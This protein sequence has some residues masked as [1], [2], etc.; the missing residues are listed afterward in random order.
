MDR[1]QEDIRRTVAAKCGISAGTPSSYGVVPGSVSRRLSN[2]SDIS[3]H[4]S[5]SG[6]SGSSSA[7]GSKT[8]VNGGGGN[9]SRLLGDFQ[10]KINNHQNN[11]SNTL[12]NGYHRHRQQHQQPV[13]GNPSSSATMGRTVNGN[14]VRVISKSSS[15]SS[16]A[17][18]GTAAT[19]TLE[20]RRR[21]SVSPH[22][23]LDRNAII[24]ASKHAAP[25]ILNAATG[26]GGSS[27]GSVGGSADRWV[28]AMAAPVM[29]TA[30]PAAAGD[31]MGQ[32]QPGTYPQL[33]RDSLT[34]NP[35]YENI[36]GFPAIPM[37][38]LH[39]QQAPPPPPPPYTGTN[40]QIVSNGTTARYNPRYF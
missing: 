32:F 10:Q 1:Y 18:G 24:A 21:S 14:N 27:K 16:L 38:G 36:E 33:K 39:L 34:S 20:N 37:R 12:N 2:G 4:G 31:V 26:S 15:A 30:E 13:I 7:A 23:A 3:S 35:I 8:M 25:K 17:R 5:S 9:V 28:A 40:H 22:T 29:I 6:G 19:S 11:L